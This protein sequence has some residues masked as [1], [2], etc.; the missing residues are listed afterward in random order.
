MRLPEGSLLRP[1][2]AQRL[3][4]V[5]K[6]KAKRSLGQLQGK[7]GEMPMAR[8]FQGALA[9][10]F[11]ASGKPAV[12]AELKGGSPE[13]FEAVGATCLSVAVDRRSFQGSYSDLATVHHSVQIPV[14]V[15]DIVVDIYQILEA[16]LAGADA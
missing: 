13:D 1:F 6:A 14:L 4:E 5:N 12:I 11:K 16:R 7:I 2:L 3:S 10:Q 9:A 8:G 15:Q